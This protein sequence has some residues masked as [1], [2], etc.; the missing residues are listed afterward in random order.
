L[1]EKNLKALSDADFSAQ[2]G[3][4]KAMAGYTK[5]AQISIKGSKAYKE[6]GQRIKPR[7]K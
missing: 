3:N 2:T 6:S 1:F 7:C 4:K 5:L